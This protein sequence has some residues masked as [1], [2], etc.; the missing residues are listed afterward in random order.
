MGTAGDQLMYERRQSLETAERK[1]SMGT[2]DAEWLEAEQATAAPGPLLNV[3][4]HA[5]ASTWV[6]HALFPCVA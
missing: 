5:G 1:R 6:V 3:L 4:G 2:E